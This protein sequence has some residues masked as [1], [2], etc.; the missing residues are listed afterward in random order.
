MASR[1]MIF[2][3]HL[4]GFVLI[5]AGLSWLALNIS[6]MPDYRLVVAL[7]AL[8]VLVVNHFRWW[9]LCNILDDREALQKVNHV[10]IANYL[11]MLLLFVLLNF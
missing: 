2:V 10:V 1:S 7:A 11:V 9:R 6:G 8:T 5:L 4:V 3:C